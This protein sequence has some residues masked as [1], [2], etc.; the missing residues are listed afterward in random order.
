MIKNVQVWKK[1]SAVFF[2][3]SLV[4]AVKDYAEL[5]EALSLSLIRAFCAVYNNCILIKHIITH[6]YTLTGTHKNAQLKNLLE[7]Q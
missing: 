5:S 3:L 6:L 2:L 4:S 1:S 7:T